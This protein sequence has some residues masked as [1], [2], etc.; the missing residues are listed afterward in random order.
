LYGA[1]KTSRKHRLESLASE[2]EGED[3]VESEI[4]NLVAKSGT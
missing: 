1:G 4:E 3:A 2:E